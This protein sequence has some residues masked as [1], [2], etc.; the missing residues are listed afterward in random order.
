VGRKQALSRATR[1]K[2]QNGSL[3]LKKIYCSFHPTDDLGL[4]TRKVYN[5]QT[6]HST[7]TR[8][9]SCKEHN[10][11]L[12]HHVLLNKISILAMKSRLRN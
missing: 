7:K 3:L 12:C 6:G 11:D 9:V 2:H 1:I 10:N 5:G 4:K 8:E